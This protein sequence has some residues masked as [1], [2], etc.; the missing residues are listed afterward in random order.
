MVGIVNNNSR[1]WRCSRWSLPCI[2]QAPSALGSHVKL[3]S[4][5]IRQVDEVDEAANALETWTLTNLSLSLSLSLPLSLSLSLSRPGLD[6]GLDLARAKG[7]SEMP[8]SW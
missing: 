6:L 3:L 7:W 1:Y 5:I 8:S 4:L 2:S